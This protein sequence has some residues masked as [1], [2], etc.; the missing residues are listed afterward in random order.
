MTE[1]AEQEWRPLALVKTS[2]DYLQQK[3]IPS[4]RLDAEVLLCAVLKCTRV[5][6]YTLYDL[7]VSQKQLA[8]YRDMIRRRVARE[9]VS[10]ILGKR[11]F[12]GYDFIV[13]PDV[14]SPRPETEILV[15]KVVQLLDTSP[16]E[17][18]SEKLFREWDR[19]YIEQ[20]KSQLAELQ[21]EDVPPELREAIAEYDREVALEKAAA[22][23]P[24]EEKVRR[25]L[26]LGTGSGCI[27]VALLKLVPNVTAVGVDVSPAALQVAERNAEALGV[28]DRIE[29]VE[30]DFFSA[31]ENAG[32]FDYVVSNPPYLVRGDRAIWPE[33]S[34]FDPEVA[35]Y[36]SADGL[37]CYKVI[38][39]R[40]GE[41]LLPGG[42]M[43]LEL[44]AGQYQAVAA[45]VR[46]RYPEAE[47]SCLADYAGIQRVL[48][49]SNIVA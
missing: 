9:P 22:G 11:E 48:V 14:L 20:V 33:V 32:K 43:L 39:E 28:A 44:G 4:P 3:G 25:V 47:M 34:G 46:E 37:A 29:F 6:L 49:V 31:L 41:F 5:K 15:E 21:K 18:R 40:A 2:A 42:G 26:D 7:T 45:M 13:T 12:M 16:K 1:S 24:P 8:V 17:K 10:R 30:S 23:N 19:K 38:V 27:P 35:L 36:A